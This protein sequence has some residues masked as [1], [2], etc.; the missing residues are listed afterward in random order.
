M[1]SAAFT[2]HDGGPDRQHQD[3]AETLARIGA[4]LTVQKASLTVQL[5][6]DLGEQALAA[7]Q[8]DETA[9]PGP[10]SERQKGV[11]RFAASL[12]LIGQVGSLEERGPECDCRLCLCSLPARRR[13]CLPCGVGANGVPVG[14][15]IRDPERASSVP[16]DLKRAWAIRVGLAWHSAGR[17]CR[18]GGC[19]R[20][21]VSVGGCSDLQA[22]RVPGSRIG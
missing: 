6:A 13:S 3:D 18:I 5:P 19:R 8:R 17:W 16:A 1:T 9:K 22:P 20:R 21:G 14:G 2:D 12:A 15:D 11:R 10:E 7:W 4:V